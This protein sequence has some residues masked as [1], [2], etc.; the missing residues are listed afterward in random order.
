MSAPQPSPKT[1]QRHWQALEDFR[2]AYIAFL[3][4]ETDDPTLREAVIATIPAA[5]ARS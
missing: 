1:L 2:V 4:D 3:D 5:D